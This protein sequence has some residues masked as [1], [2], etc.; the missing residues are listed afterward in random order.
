LCEPSP[1]ARRKVTH[2]LW[3]RA[4]NPGVRVYPRSDEPG[5]RAVYE[6]WD[7]VVEYKVNWFSQSE[8]YEAEPVKF[9]D[10]VDQV[11][12]VYA[13]AWSNGARRDRGRGGGSY[14]FKLRDGL[15]VEWRHYVSHQQVVWAAAVTYTPGNQEQ[16]PH[17]QRLQEV[18]RSGRQ[19]DRRRRRGHGRETPP[20]VEHRQACALRTARR[21]P[22]GGLGYSSPAPHRRPH[23]RDP[24]R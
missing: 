19:R 17:Q 22:L 14:S 5:V 12:V 16:A 6:G 15:I 8:D 9:L 18:V 3:L 21:A 7:G 24:R 1:N 4:M 13:R 10:A 20:L 2:Q 11:L 23:L